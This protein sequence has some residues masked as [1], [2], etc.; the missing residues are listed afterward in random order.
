MDRHS[1]SF[2]VDAVLHE[3]DRDKIAMR[4]LPTL[5]PLL[6]QKICSLG[7]IR[8]VAASG[9]SLAHLRLAYSRDV[10][11]GIE[12]LLGERDANSCVRV[13]KSKK[14]INSISKF[15]SIT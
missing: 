2:S 10:D 3:I 4:N 15:L 14:I 8:K 13:T 5:Q 7:T 11:S 12:L 1:H 6:D 9:L